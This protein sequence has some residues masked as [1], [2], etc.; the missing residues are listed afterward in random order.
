MARVPDI[1]PISDLR[2]DAAAVLK[3]VRNSSEPVLITQR[4]RA[5]A[6]LLSV[7]AYERSEDERQLL[8]AL[9]RGD[10]EISAG[11]G[12][13]LVEVLREADKLLEENRK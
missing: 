1:V 12:H 7:D 13:D 5:A 11:T 9:A 10:R 6:V 3:R 2:Q 8:R 4:G